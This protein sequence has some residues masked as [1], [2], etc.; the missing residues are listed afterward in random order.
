M[1]VPRFLAPLASQLQDMEARANDL[2]ADSPDVIHEKQPDGRYQL[3][4]KK[5][6]GAAAQP[7]PSPPT[8]LGACCTDGFCQVMSESDC[9]GGG[10][11]YLGDE[12]DCSGVD[13]TSGACCQSNPAIAGECQDLSSPLLCTGSNIWHGFGTTCADTRCEGA[14][15]VC[16]PCA[17]CFCPGCSCF[18]S[19]TYGEC[20][21]LLPVDGSVGWLL[22][23]DC[24]INDCCYFF[25][26]P[27]CCGDPEGSCCN[28]PDFFPCFGPVTEASCLSDGGTWCAGGECIDN[29]TCP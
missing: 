8:A 3:R 11:D 2:L 28:A 13:C 25:S 10:G 4:L 29:F 27:P 9:T 7:P 21:D 22:D 14:C 19:L 5:P 18:N 20:Q 15:A 17:D 16:T 23:G 1:M 6:T 26:T 12:T 24:S